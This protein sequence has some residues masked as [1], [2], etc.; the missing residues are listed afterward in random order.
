MC[1]TPWAKRAQKCKQLKETKTILRPCCDAGWTLLSRVS[2][3]AAQHRASHCIY[4]SEVWNVAQ[5]VQHVQHLP[6][7]PHPHCLLPAGH[8]G[9]VSHC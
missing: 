7:H 2:M 1:N 9:T 3:S 6:H 5:Q 8:Q 4:L